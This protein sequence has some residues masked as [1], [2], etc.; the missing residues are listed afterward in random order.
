LPGIE[1]SAVFEAFRMS[2]EIARQVIQ[3]GAMA[4]EI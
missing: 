3:R 4:R 2:R 1:P